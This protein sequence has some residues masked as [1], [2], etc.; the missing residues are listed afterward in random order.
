MHRR[1]L[2][3]ALWLLHV[4]LLLLQQ[5]LC[6]PCACSASG[7]GLLTLTMT[8][9]VVSYMMHTIGSINTLGY[10]FDYCM[11]HIHGI[12]ASLCCVILHDSWLP[13]HNIY[14]RNTT[15]L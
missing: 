12:R 3:P 13:K 5:L 1:Q 10:L 14:A 15:Q 4:L 8:R 9:D 11:S 7:K 6:P 2:P